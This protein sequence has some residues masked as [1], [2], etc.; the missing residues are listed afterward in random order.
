MIR[1]RKYNSIKTKE[2]F[3]SALFL[4]YPPTYVESLPLEVNQWTYIDDLK[5]VQIK[6]DN[7]KEAWISE[8]LG[9][10]EV[11]DIINVSVE[12][13]NISGAKAKISI[14]DAGEDKE[15]SST[16]QSEWEIL[17]LKYVVRR[18][19]SHV[20][21]AGIWK[22]DVGEFIMRNIKYEILSQSKIQQGAIVESGENSNGHYIKFSDG[23][24][25]CRGKIIKNGIIN[26]TWG[27]LFYM[28]LYKKTYP[29]PFK[30]PPDV[31]F[32]CVGDRAFFI[33][34]FFSIGMSDDYK[35][36]NTPNIEVYRAVADDIE[37]NYEVS[38]IAI[39]KWK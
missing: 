30:S 34:T 19:N 9:N 15:I 2:E 12:V 17:N 28:S 18:N 11:G 37:W 29:M 1:D 8:D 3:E 35:S 21:Y 27:S 25:I 23:T 16:K 4:V 24:M 22:S 10:L 32:S 20:L 33:G 39:G 13:Y 7:T 14:F 5:A 31:T 26:Q 36:K 38:Y 6:T